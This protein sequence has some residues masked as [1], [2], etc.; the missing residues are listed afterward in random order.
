M[1]SC[2]IRSGR[3]VGICVFL[4]LDAFKLIVGTSTTIVYHIELIAGVAAQTCKRS[5]QRSETCSR[6]WTANTQPRQ[7]HGH[8]GAN[9]L[10]I[11]FNWKQK[12][13]GERANCERTR[14]LEQ[15]TGSR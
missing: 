11:P 12:F 5:K 4:S 10:A 14:R 7:T 13:E 2:T 9:G 1:Q 3:L 6:H 15:L 8:S